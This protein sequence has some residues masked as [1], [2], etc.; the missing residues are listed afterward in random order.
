V[1]RVGSA[2]RHGKDLGHVQ[3]LAKSPKL[4][5]AIHLPT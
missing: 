3:R 4:T 2:N 5:S 1:S